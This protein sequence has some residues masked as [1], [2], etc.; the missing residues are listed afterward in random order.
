MNKNVSNVCPVFW[1]QHTSLISHEGFVP[2][3]T[4]F[5]NSVHV[6]YILQRVWFLNSRSSFVEKD[7][8]LGRRIKLLFMANSAVT[9]W[10]E[11]TF[12][13]K[14][15]GVIFIFHLRCYNENF[16]SVRLEFAKG[17]MIV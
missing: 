16:E 11:S 7:F 10:F 13:R 6:K 1:S 2:K 3:T 14:S 4:Y 9:L 17:T 12:E 8:V 5:L 15:S